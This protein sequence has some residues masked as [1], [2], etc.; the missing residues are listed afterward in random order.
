MQTVTFSIPDISC[1]HCVHTI[2]M[3]LGDIKGV[4]S[5]DARADTKQATITF[6]PPATEEQLKSTLAAIKYPVDEA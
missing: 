3:E 2:K 6:E 4:F 5:V 1:N